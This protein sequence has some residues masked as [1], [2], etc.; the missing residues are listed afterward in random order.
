MIA[1]ILA[2]GLGKRLKPF[3]EVIPK[4]LL[5][6][7]ESN[8]LE[9]QIKFLAKSG[10]EE[11]YIATNYKFEL[12][13]AYLGNGSKYGVKLFYSQENKPLGTIGP[14]S[15]LK[16][17]ITSPFIL[18]N[19][20]V[21]TN[22]N[23]KNFYNYGKKL[24]Y[25]LTVGTIPI[26]IPFNFGIIKSNGNFIT[27]VIEKPKF[28]NEILSGIYFFKPDILKYIPNG[29]YLGIDILIKFLLKKKIKI[30]KYNIVDFWLDIGQPDSYKKAQKVYKKFFN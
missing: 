21:L 27:S 25:I 24:N 4:P 13:K 5:P 12:V 2:G 14:V 18:I 30:G 11:I 7:G 29:K 20:D 28:Y 19:G 3:T 9:I 17:K 8:I 15:L 22:L 16:K 1:I 10:F 26:K 23:F 6:I